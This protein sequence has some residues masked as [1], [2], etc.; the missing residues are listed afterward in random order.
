MAYIIAGHDDW[1]GCEIKLFAAYNS[2]NIEGQIRKLNHLVTEGRIPISIKN[3]H[4]LPMESGATL[5][6]I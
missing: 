1:R 5:L 4:R 3:V 6:T 2:E